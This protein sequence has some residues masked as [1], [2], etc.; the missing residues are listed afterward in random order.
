MGYGFFSLHPLPLFLYYV[1]AIILIMTFYHPVFL[2]FSLLILISINFIHDK[3]KKLKSYKKFY[4]F[5]GIIIVL[6]NP[7]ISSRG[8]TVLFYV[9]DKVITLESFVYGI[10]TMLSLIS[11]MVLF[12]SYNIIITDDKFMYLFSDILPKTSFLIMM[13]MGFVPLLK[14]RAE[15]INIVQRLKGGE[16]NNNTFKKKIIERMKILNILVTWSLEESIIRARSMRARGYGVTK[17][18]SYYFNYKMDKLDILVLIFIIFSVFI[19]LFSWNMEIINYEIYPKVSPIILNFKTLLFLILY[20]LY[21]GIPIIIEGM[22][23]RK[24]QK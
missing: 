10:C 14:R 11:I 7:I 5:M 6:I 20:L 12:L 23:K 9:F 17:D 8:E 22:D 1:G 18:R 24:W 4:I 15:E 3:G 19:L 16:G 13:S 2:I 21:L